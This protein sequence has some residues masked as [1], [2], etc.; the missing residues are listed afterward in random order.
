[1]DIVLE[2]KMDGIETANKIH[3]LFNVPVIYL[4]GHDEEKFLEKA[5]IAE[6]FGYLIKPF[7]EKELR[8]TIEM[9]LYKSKM[10]NELKNDFEKWQRLTVQRENR[11]LELKE[12]INDLRKRLDFEVL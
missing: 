5:K 2:G 10:E 6:P 7:K 4:T 11:M 9:A 12:E 1:M 3:S 8:A